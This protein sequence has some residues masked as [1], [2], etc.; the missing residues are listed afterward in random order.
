MS[1]ERNADSGKPAQGVLVAFEHHDVD[2]GVVTRD[3]PCGQVDSAAPGD[4][5]RNGQ[6]RQQR[7]DGV[8][9]GAGHRCGDDAALLVNRELFGN[10]IWQAGTASQGL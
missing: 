8:V 1:A 3:V 2:I 6:A 5:P 10:S 4:P 7:A 9:L